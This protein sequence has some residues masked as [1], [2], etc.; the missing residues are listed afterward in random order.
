MNKPNFKVGDVV[1]D[2]NGSKYKVKAIVDF[3]N[4]K[5]VKGYDSTGALA[6]MMENYDEYSDEW[7][8]VAVEDLEASEGDY[9]KQIVFGVS[10][11]SN[12][13]GQ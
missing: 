11:D 5:L 9:F 1:E 2:Y 13:L 12:I 4:H 7:W 10:P 6:E 8:L 3:E